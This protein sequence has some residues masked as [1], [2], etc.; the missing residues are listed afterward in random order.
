MGIAGRI[1]EGL[2]PLQ[3]DHFGRHDHAP[4]GIVGLGQPFEGDLDLRHARRNGE[5]EGI[6]V[7]GVTQPFDPLAIGGDCQAGEEL[8]RAGIG[9]VAG[10]EFRIEQ[11]Q[12]TGGDRNGLLHPDDPVVE[13]GGVDVVADGARVGAI[14]GLRDGR[15]RPGQG[16]GPDLGQGRCGPE[17]QGGGAGREQQA[18]GGT[19]HGGSF[20]RGM[21]GQKRLK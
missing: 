3:I 2:L 11:G 20:E 12:V 4:D 13:V 16:G 14:L 6:G 18:G 5:V 9:V 10:D 15:E 17:H 7:K 21:S 1:E 19:H 8:D